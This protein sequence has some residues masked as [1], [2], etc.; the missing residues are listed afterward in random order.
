ML[1]TF[2]KKCVRGIK[3]DKAR[4]LAF[5]EMSVSIATALNPVIGYEKAAETVKTALREGK[6]IKQVV[7][8]TKLMSE[9]KY[10]QTVQLGKMVDPHQRNSGRK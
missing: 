8:E 4:C 7:L 1:E 5:A 2:E 9:E 10:R 3:A 6:T